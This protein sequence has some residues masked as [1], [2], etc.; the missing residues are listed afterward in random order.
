VTRPTTTV[1]VEVIAANIESRRRSKDLREL[2]RD[3]KPDVVVVEQAYRARRFLSRT[4]KRLGY[5]HHQYE[6]G[7]G[8]EWTGIAV[9]VSNNVNIIRTK[10]LL[11]EREWVGPKAG[12]RHEPRVYP[13]LVLRKEGVTFRVIGIH[14]ETHNQ[15]RAQ[16][17]SLREIRGYFNG[18][19]NSPIIAAGDWNRKA[20]ELARTAERTDA[21][22]LTGKTK[23][24]HALVARADNGNR[25]RLP[26]PD[27]A[28]G[29][30]RYRVTLHRP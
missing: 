6:R 1:P 25:D 2:I 15:P 21:E 14:L 5:Q 12:K 20:H 16:V 8:A 22:V 30:A 19:P 18:H 23:V 3:N 10:P 17:E 13:T 29:W 4:A 7:P 26:T 9:L 28:H 27:G 11:M 24:D